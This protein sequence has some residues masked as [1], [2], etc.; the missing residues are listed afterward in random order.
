VRPFFFFWKLMTKLID[1]VVSF[2]EN[3][4]GLVMRQDQH[5]PD[6]FISRLKQAKIE[7]T[8][9]RAGEFM[10]ACSI[11]TALADHWMRVDKYNVFTAPVEETVKRLRKEGLDAFIVTNKRI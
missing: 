3:V 11:P 5:I 2:D 1:S 10:H 9:E 7:S 8:A 4:D 6:D